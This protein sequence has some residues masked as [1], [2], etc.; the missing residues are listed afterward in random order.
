LGTGKTQSQC[1]DNLD[2]QK[3]LEKAARPLGSPKRPVL[4]GVL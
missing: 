1:L 3:V 2:N 4:G